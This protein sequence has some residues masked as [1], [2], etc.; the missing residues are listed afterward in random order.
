VDKL[1]KIH[2]CFSDKITLKYKIILFFIPV[3]IIPFIF[4]A[5]YSSK[6]IIDSATQKAVID[7]EDK[8]ILISRQFD[9]LVNDIEYSIKLFSAN[10]FLHDALNNKEE[11]GLGDVRLLS[12]INN[13]FSSYIYLSKFIDKT[14]IVTSDEKIYMINQ[15]TSSLQPDTN[16][17]ERNKILMVHN[18]TMDARGKILWADSSGSQ[19]D[20][21]GFAGDETYLYLSKAVQDITTGNWLG[22][23]I[24]YINKNAAS[25][26]YEGIKNGKTGKYFIVNR[27]GYV[28]SSGDKELFEKS[29]INEEFFRWVTENGTGGKIFDINGKKE[30]V[31]AILLNKVDWYLVGTVPINELTEDSVRIRMLIV[32]MG[33]ISVFVI[34]AV[35]F[36]IANN[37]T[38]PLSVLINFTKKIGDGNLDIEVCTGSKGEIG[39]L[40]S[41]M[42]SMI[43]RI[44][45]LIAKV[46]YEQRK[47]RE[48]ELSLLQSQINPHFLYNALN[49]VNSLLLEKNYDEGREIIYNLGNYYKLVLSKGMDTVTIEKEIELT[50]SYLKI[51]KIR[52]EDLFDFEMD[53]DD[54]IKQSA[55]PKLTLQPLVENSIK[56]GFRSSLRKNRITIT[57]FKEN[58]KIIIE[59]KDNGKGIENCDTAGVI[60]GKNSDF[61]S[62]GFGLRNV[63][64]RIKLRFGEEYGI[65]LKAVP[66]E[67]MV[68]T[69]CL[70][71]SE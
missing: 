49:N 47:K 59:V 37:I 52:H 22:S 7:S 15:N 35:S 8:M 1:V 65:H 69:I 60:Y 61:N 25:S 58:N 27:D 2:D 12:D 19:S 54:S 41:Q 34:A 32:F 64:E 33:L 18:G 3:I 55:I 24:V 38:K 10:K 16:I 46:L 13:I 20:G 23:I 48:Y 71:Y 63:N 4:L 42:N 53:I 57:G 56:H 50:V 51:M 68:V 6:V 70:P 39:K 11:G 36:A 43:Q 67:G 14:I 62:K 30:L 5:L 40:E 66:D 21:D 17:R 31:T 44:R 29:I 9:T 26:I 45:E 28:V